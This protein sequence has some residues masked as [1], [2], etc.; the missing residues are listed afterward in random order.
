[1]KGSLV[2][3][4]ASFVIN[5]PSFIIVNYDYNNRVKLCL[6]QSSDPLIT[7]HWESVPDLNGSISQASAF[8]IRQ[9]ASGYHYLN[10]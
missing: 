10:W 3:L 7:R 6:I 2:K 9:T 8:S 4:N 5:S 1:M